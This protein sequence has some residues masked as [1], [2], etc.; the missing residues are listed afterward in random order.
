MG[1][2]TIAGIDPGTSKCGVCLMRVI[3]ET[4]EILELRSETIRCERVFLWNNY[5]DP[6]SAE[7]RRHLRLCGLREDLIRFYRHEMIDTWVIESSFAR[8]LTISAIGPLVEAM[9]VIK[10]A[11]REIDLG[12]RIVKMAP[13]EVRALIGA[14]YKGKE[15]VFRA[16]MRLLPRSI[17]GL[18][19][20]DDNAIDSIALALAYVC[21]K[22]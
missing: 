1:P 2:I 3:P 6:V 10:E 18:Q 12:A 4:R 5:A 20:L 11:A 21:K 8:S 22:Y 14:D 13:T 16:V 19:Q 9:V 15:T 7:D 17:E